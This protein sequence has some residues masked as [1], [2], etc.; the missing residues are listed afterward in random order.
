MRDVIYAPWRSAPARRWGA[1]GLAAAALA[2][3]PAAAGAQDRAAAASGLGRVSFGVDVSLN[4]A[5][6]DDTAFFNYTDYANDALRG[7]H[8]RL[9]TEWRPHTRLAF[10]AEV[11]TEG[12]DRLRLP[13]LYVTWRPSGAVDLAVQAG[14]IP[15]LIGSFPRR[16]YGRD[17]SVVG[18]P[19]AYQY[20]TSLRPDALPSSTEDLLRM[21]GRGW[22]PSFP[23][24]SS[25]PA[26]GIPLVSSSRWDTGVQLS[27]RR[28]IVETAAALTVGAPATPLVRDNSRGQQWSGR[29]AVGVPSGPTL[30]V[31]AARGPWIEDGVI[32]QLPQARDGWRTAQRVIAFDA[33]YGAGPWLA[34]A[35]WLRSSFDVPIGTAGASTALVAQSGFVEGRYR[36]FPRW[37]VG[38]RV[39]RLGFSHLTR[40]ADGA[41]VSWDA[42]VE[43]V[44]GVIGYR[45]TRSLE[46]RAGYQQNWRTG[47][48]VRSRG[49][50]LL[51]VLY[52]R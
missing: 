16:A 33:E 27:W 25:E 48:R 9:V 13:A 10:I 26:T 23:I 22:L 17:Q 42:D 21:R 29:V 36:P 41:R 47:G 24:G 44:E 2:G 28:G 3:V 50:P 39:E 12:A 4:L 31:S 11:R 46:V 45:V 5:P 20:L 40:P 18:V 7:G 51:A 52:W 15:P 14:R 49:F 30:G 43:R 38:L 6:R 8:A 1:A 35:E 37:Q 32:A 34:R 19:L